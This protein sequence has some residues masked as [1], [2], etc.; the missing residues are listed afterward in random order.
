M[1][2]MNGRLGHFLGY[3]RIFYEVACCKSFTRA[4]ERLHISQPA[5]TRQIKNLEEVLGV[6]LFDRGSTPVELTPAGKI[7]LSY[8]AKTFALIEEAEEALTR[9]RREAILRIGTTKGY[10]KS[11]MPEIISRFQEENPEVKIVLQVESSKALQEGVLKGDLDLAI[12]ANPD[13]EEKSLL[14]IPFRREALVC[15]A[16]AR[17]GLDSSLT[18]LPLEKVTEFP[19]IVRER[20][21]GTHKVVMDAFK[22]LGRRPMVLI[23]ASSPEFIKEWVKAGKGLS[24]V[25]ASSVE[26]ERREGKLIVLPLVPPLWLDVFVVLLKGRSG[27]PL[28]CCFLRYLGCDPAML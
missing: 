20:G 28:V 17:L 23:E 16:S 11:T 19:F 1:L 2:Y 21:S 9:Y 12:L 14:F 6:T 18:P 10:S 13:F 27:E 3:L 24:I 4:A 25:T 22:G 8:V 5:V 15:I 7:L 26:E